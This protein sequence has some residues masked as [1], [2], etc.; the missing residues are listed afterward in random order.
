MLIFYT[1]NLHFKPLF[2][3]RRRNSGCLRKDEFR[4][5]LNQ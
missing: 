2:I 5:A 3:R 1:S 4:Y